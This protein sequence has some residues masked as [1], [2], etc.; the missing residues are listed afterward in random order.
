MYFSRN[1]GLVYNSPLKHFPDLHEKTDI[2]LGKG[3]SVQSEKKDDQQRVPLER[4]VEK[5]K[6]IKVKK[7]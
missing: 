5:L 6:N 3:V 1:R 7:K 2:I 4:L